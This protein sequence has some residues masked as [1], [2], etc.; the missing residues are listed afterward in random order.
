MN[1]AFDSNVRYGVHAPVVS[2]TSA[3]SSEPLC[4]LN[5]GNS[6]KDLQHIDFA[7]LCT[8][9][10]LLCVTFLSTANHLHAPDCSY[11]SCNAPHPIPV[12]SNIGYNNYNNRLGPAPI[13]ADVFSLKVYLWC[14]DAG[15]SNTSVDA[16]S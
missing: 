13:L 10:A 3:L 14:T 2:G 5:D 15:L 7:L 6:Q 8:T 11:F 12:S 4:K 16:T 9:I 1:D